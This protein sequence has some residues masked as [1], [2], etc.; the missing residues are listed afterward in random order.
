MQATGLLSGQR[1]WVTN[2]ANLAALIY[3]KLH[4]D[5]STHP[6]GS[7]VNWV[8]FYFVDPSDSKKLILGPFQGKPA[9]TEIRIG[10]GVCGKC[11]ADRSTVL[12]PNVHEFEGHIA[13]DAASKSELVIPLI[14]P[15]GRFLGVLDLDSTVHEG[16]NDIDT[17]ALEYIVKILVDSCDF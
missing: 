6:K 10:R 2:T 9:C 16:F 7:H 4:S 15:D 14:H 1:H 5:K 3:T 12:V 13:C 17:A 11:F 8:G